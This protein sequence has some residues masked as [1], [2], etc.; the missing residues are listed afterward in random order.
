MDKVLDKK[1]DKVLDKILDKNGQIFGQKIGQS[2]WKLLEVGGTGGTP[3]A[4]TQEDCLV[5]FNF[6]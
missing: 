6:G 5:V 3:L 4:V 1:M 2:F